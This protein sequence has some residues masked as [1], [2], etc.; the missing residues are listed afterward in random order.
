MSRIIRKDIQSVRD[1]KEALNNYCDDLYVNFGTHKLGFEINGYGSDG[2]S[3]G[4]L[5]D[6]LEEY[7]ENLEK[8]LSTYAI[9][10]EVEGH[11]REEY[12]YEANNIQEALGQFFMDNP[13]ISYDDI[14]EHLE[15]A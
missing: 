14:I 15:I 6:D 7:I 9:Y 5:S 11:E 1:L 10:V 4:M 2:L 13:C 12:H 3:F 8:E